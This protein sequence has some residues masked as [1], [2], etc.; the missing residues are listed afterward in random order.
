MRGRKMHHLRAGDVTCEH[1][2]VS[3]PRQ[4][5]VELTVD[6]EDRHANPFQRRRQIHVANGRAAAGVPD[7][8]RCEQRP[9]RARDDVRILGETSQREEPAHHHVGDGAHP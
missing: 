7:G 3:R 2:P 8:I 5:R 9:P 1:I 4:R 6:H